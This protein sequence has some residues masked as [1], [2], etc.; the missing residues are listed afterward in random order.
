LRRALTAALVA[1]FLGV[2][3]PVGPAF[4]ASTA[5]VVVVVGPVGSHTAHYTAD[6]RAIAAEA[7]RYT[8]NVAL[9]VTPGATW[10]RVKAAAQ[11][12]NILVYLGHGNGWPSVYAPFETLTK[13]GLG[14]DP[15]G[16]AKGTRTAYYGEGPIRDGIRLAPNA[17]VL[18]FHLCYASGNT[19]PGLPPGT[20]ADARQRVDNFGAGFIGAGA[21]AVFAE[22]H[23]E[24]PVASYIR[25]LFTTDRTM[26][27]VFRAAPTWH[28]NLQ[29]PFASQRTPGLRFELD[30]D[31]AGPT[32]FYRSLVGDLG[33]RASSVV[34]P[35]LTGTGGNPAG[36]AVPGAAEVI[37]SGGAGLFVTA[38]AAAAPSRRAAATLPRGTAVRLVSEARPTKG[39]GSRVF[40]VTILGR[41]TK[42]FVRARD[43]APRDSASIRLWTLDQ[44]GPVLSPN[45]DGQADVLVVAARFSERAGVTLTVRNAA[46]TVVRRTSTTGDIVRLEWNLK[47]PAGGPARDGRYTWTLSVAPDARGNGGL[48]RTGSFAIDATGPVTTARVDARTGGGGWLASPGTVSLSAKDALSGLDSIAWALDGGAVGTYRKPVAVVGNGTHT[49]RYRATDRSGI[50]EGWKSLVL[51]IDT[52][53]PTV[54]LPLGGRPGDRPGTWRGPVTITPAVSDATSGAAG[55]TASVD[56]APATAMRGPSLVVKGEGRHTVTFTAADVAGNTTTATTTFTID[57]VA[58]I[59]T[60]PPA[61]APLPLVTP[62]GD[63]RSERVSLPYSVSEPASVTATITADGGTV[64]RTLTGAA[65]TGANALAWDGRTAAGTPVPDGRYTVTISGRDPVG[66]TGGGATTK[67]D[68]YAAL[69]GLA[70]TPAAFFPQ[71]GDRLAPTTTASFTL[72]SPAKVTVRVLDPTGVVVRT[73]MSDR[74]LPAGAVGWSWDG[75]TDAG[76]FASRGTYRI[77]VTAGNGAQFATQETTVVADAFRVTTSVSTAIRGRNLTITAVSSEPLASAPR[78]TVRQ[79]GVRAWSVAMKR[80]GGV[81]WVAVIAPRKGG[82]AG[83][84]SLS[85]RAT[86]SSRGTNTSALALALR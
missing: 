37:A 42:G 3:A 72:R 11:G 27:Q 49:L 24:H 16:G 84:L 28:G 67:V 31:S 21:R 32:G 18:L 1:L 29:G 63:G 20:F 46:G 35:R 82:S 5:K 85:I 81:T 19:E 60:I 41:T 22:G 66:N 64:V 77:A 65:G 10:A 57:S 2:A 52:V 76:A 23:P 4:A 86:D 56:G 78:V 71:D 25:Q 36:F 15:D 74:S 59:I 47:T 7:R 55:R 9:I 44:S 50:R 26:D 54:G 40:R 6:A 69:A 17:V 34:A 43:L 30:S 8:P 83:T 62:N 51:R 80:T 79:P 38:A 68:V 75:R 13:D 33:L 61:G 48:T 53:P 14:L 45:G 58:P 12:A 73:G 39:G 70:R